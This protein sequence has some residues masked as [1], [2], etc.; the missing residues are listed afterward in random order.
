MSLT[1][2]IRGYGTVTLAESVTGFDNI[3]ITAPELWSEIIKQG[4]GAIGFQASSKDGAG[5]FELGTGLNFTTTE[6]GQNIMMWVNFTTAGTLIDNASGGGMYLLAGSSQTDYLMY[7][8][9]DRDYQEQIGR[10]FGRFIFDPTKTPTTTVGTPDLTA[11]TLFGVWVDGDL[12]SR[13]DNLFIDRID[14]GFGL[15]VKGTSNQ[16]WLD[17]VTDDALIANKYGILEN[18][19]DV[20]F[21]YAGIEIGDNIGTDLTQF[22]DSDRTIQFVSQYYYTSITGT[23]VAPMISDGY[24]GITLVDNA[25][26]QTEFTDGILVGSDLGRNG[27]TIKGSKLHTTNFDASAM[28]N[29]NSFIKLYNTSLKQMYGDFKYHDNSNSLFYGGVISGCEQFDVVGSAVLRN[30]TISGYTGTLGALLWNENI[31]IQKCSFIANTD[32][33]NNPSAIEHSLSVG[34]PYNYYDLT[35]SGNDYDGI[36]TSGVAIDVNLNGLSD[37]ISDNPSGDIMNY[38]SSATLKFVVKDS[39][40]LPV[41]DAYAYIDDDNIDPY[42]MN[43]QTDI[44]GEASVGHTAGAV[45]GARWRVRKYGYY[46]F[47]QLIDI[48]ASGLKEVG[49]ELRSHPQQ[50]YYYLSASVGVVSDI[51]DTETHTYTIT[52]NREPKASTMTIANITQEVEDNGTISNIVVTG[53]P[54]IWEFDFTADVGI[55]DITNYFKVGVGVTDLND[56]AMLNHAISQNFRIVNDRTE[57]VTWTTSSSS[58]DPMEFTFKAPLGAVVWFND[59]EYVGNDDINVPVSIS[60][61]G[62]GVDFKIEEELFDSI[63]SIISTYAEFEGSLPDLSVRANFIYLEVKHNRLT[64]IIPEFS[65]LNSVIDRFSIYSQ[66]S[67]GF[68]G[69]LTPTISHLTGVSDLSISYNNLGGVM[70]DLSNLTY[71]VYNLN[72]GDNAFISYNSGGAIYT[73]G[74]FSAS[75]NDISSATD[76]NA[77]LADLKAGQ[78]VTGDLNCTVNISGGTNASPTGQGITDKDD[79]IALGWT[80]TTN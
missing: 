68:T 36:N 76:I 2:G 79:L 45:L 71:P 3:T 42:I 49:V 14:V 35:F 48:P 66:H 6:L 74:N 52:F 58:P 59:V 8:V 75:N 12:A 37:A 23:T 41:V 78:L 20:Y 47:T 32:V 80:V 43:T 57:F 73:T 38:L 63:T 18:I 5:V 72:L 21:A 65:V 44:N 24:M 29:A 54:L 70:P 33:T 67:G 27:S 64:G 69:G 46:P 19:Q 40:Q 51:I 16:G 25:T 7:K 34:S 4:N 17:I 62:V 50:S 39:N 61:L 56:V 30:L 28:T 10:G 1:I 53:N 77:I 60:G 9:A 13:A 22:L 26:N 31:D 55:S 11:I 15:T